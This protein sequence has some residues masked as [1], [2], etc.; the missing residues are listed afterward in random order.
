MS[1]ETRNLSRA[2]VIDCSLLYVNMT[3]VYTDGGDQT[4]NGLRLP[5][6][7]VAT[8]FHD[9][10]RTYQTRTHVCVD[11]YYYLSNPCCLVT[12]THSELFRYNAAHSLIS[13]KWVLPTKSCFYACVCGYVYKQIRSNARPLLL[14]IRLVMYTCVCVCIYMCVRVCV[15]MCVC[16][17]VCVCVCVYSKLCSNED[18]PQIFELVVIPTRAQNGE[19]SFLLRVTSV[20]KRKCNL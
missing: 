6:F 11:E 9:S 7:P 1:R 2:V 15:C 19:N 20:A 18:H 13:V 16:M 8:I 17:C 5:N 10:L 12:V 3:C 14:I 4:W